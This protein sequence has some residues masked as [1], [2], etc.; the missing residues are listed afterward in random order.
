MDSARG[1]DRARTASGTGRRQGGRSGGRALARRRRRGGAGARRIARARVRRAAGARPRAARGDRGDRAARS[2][3]ASRRTSTRSSPRRRAQPGSRRPPTPTSACSA[4]GSAAPSAACSASPSRASR[5]RGSARSP[6]APATGRSRGYFTARGLDP[7]VSE[8]FPW[9]RASRPT[10]LVENINGMPEDDDLNFTMLAV[11]LL[12]RHGGAFTSA[13]VAK[14]WLD[15]LP[16]GRIFTAER[17]AL[18]QPLLA[19]LP[20]ETATYNNPFREWIGARLRVDVYGWASPGDPSRAARLAWEDARVSH[21]ANGVYAAMFMAAAHAATLGDG[22][23]GPGGRRRARG[24]AGREPARRGDPLRAGPR[25]AT[26][27]RSSTR[28]TSAT[29]PAL[30]ARDQ[31]HGARRRRD[32]PLHGV[33]RGDLRRRRGRLGHRHERRGGRLDLRAAVGP[34]STARWSEPAARPLRELAARL[35]RRTFESSRAARSRVTTTPVRRDD[36]AEAP[37]DPWSPRPIDRPTAVPLGARRSTGWTARRSSPRPD[38]PADWPRLARSRS[39]AGVERARA[40]ATTA[41]ATTSRRSRGR[42]RASPSRSSGSGTSCSTTSSAGQFTPE[43]FARRRPSASSAASTASCS[44]TRIPVIGIDDRNQFDWYRD[45]PGIRELVA[46]LQAAGVRVFVDYNPWDVGTRREP[47]DDAHGVAELVAW[48]GADGVFL[49]TMKEAPPALR[50]ALDARR[51]GIAF[52]GESTL[53]LARIARPPPL[54]GAVVRR[55]PRARRDP[56]ALVR[57][58]AHA[59]PHPPL[60][61]RPRRGAAVELA[62]RRRHARLGG[63]LRR[64]GSAGTTAT[65]A[66]L[67]TMVEVQRRHV[68]LLTRGEWTPLAARRATTCR[69]SGRAGGSATTS[70]G[71]REPRRRAVRG[72]RRPRRPESRADRAGPRDRCARAR[73]S[74]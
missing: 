38:D 30:G 74:A 46:A 4:P 52:E 63:R 58:A 43:R 35:R 54:L 70:L 20:P 55:Q 34:A 72:D 25:A 24:R 5:A 66:L 36:P 18:P 9:N 1:S 23:R 12:E 2:R 60:E 67:R 28:C 49:D 7:A 8:R 6:R 16:P 15:F 51:P 56:R 61:P 10:S 62:E 37:R 42:S 69:S 59:P 73:R 19:L 41:R 71:P 50:A 26:G 44:G 57:A 47:A 65:A 3:P 11:A 48:L 21:T 17:V 29:A 68:D 31:Q 40:S 32:V 14:I 13:D 39:R 53:P 33:R 27:S 45:V 22:R 64:R